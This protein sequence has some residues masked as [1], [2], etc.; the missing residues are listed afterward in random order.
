MAMNPRR[1]APVAA[2]MLSMGC[3]VAGVGSGAQHRDDARNPGDERRVCGI[4]LCWCPPGTFLMGSPG[5]E[6]GRRVDEQQVE[7]TLTHGFWMGKYEV[8]QGE[9][10]RVVGPLP[11]ELLV[12]KG[13]D[14]P[15][16][17][18]SYVQAEEFCRK[19]TAEA[20][21]ADGLP[22]EWEFRIP[23]EAQWEYACRA[24]TTTAF[25]FGDELSLAQANFG[26]WKKGMSE[27]PDPSAEKVGTYAANAWGIHDMHGNEFEWCRDWYHQEREGGVDPDLSQVQGTPNRD[28]TYSRVRRGGAWTDEPWACRSACRIRFEPERSANHIGFRVALV[29][30]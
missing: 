4:A 7:V 1:L 15:A 21:V 29:R 26:R 23:T 19:L 25:C 27:S 12:G 9:W 17:W 11:G 8:T 20:R 6:V 10:C 14:F 18:I 28:G 3:E 30:R 16:Y 24:G 22:P 13:E 5:T 2:L